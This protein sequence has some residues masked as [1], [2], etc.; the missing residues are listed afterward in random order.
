MFTSGAYFQHAGKYFML[1]NDYQVYVAVQNGYWDNGDIRVDATTEIA[2]QW[3]HDTDSINL[4]MYTDYKF[5]AEISLNSNNQI[6]F[7][8]VDLAG[9]TE[10]DYMWTGS[11]APNLFQ[12]ITGINPE[13]TPIDLS[14]VSIFTQELLSS[15]TFYDVYKNYENGAWDENFSSLT[16][17]FDS[18]T[19]KIAEGISE[20]WVHTYNSFEILE[21][22]MLKYT[23]DFNMNND[24]NFQPVDR[25][26][27]INSSTQ[28]RLFV[29]YGEGY[30]TISACDENTD[31][32][33]Y[34]FVD[35]IKAQ[36]FMN[37]N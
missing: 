12:N 29:C 24:T 11:D 36:T 21:N 37:N 6:V 28:D 20:N 23:D 9:Y 7:S 5:S 30:D 27:K 19:I 22:G 8:Y 26:I 32:N 4:S 18:G 1:K 33:E 17:K 13:S 34:L 14:S 3:S 2:G 15:I 16:M 31:N 35:S 25:Y 10:S